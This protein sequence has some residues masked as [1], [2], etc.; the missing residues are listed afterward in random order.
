MVAEA[1]EIAEYKVQTRDHRM[2]YTR[3]FVIMTSQEIL[4]SGEILLSGFPITSQTHLMK[5]D[6]VFFYNPDGDLEKVVGHEI[7]THDEKD[8]I[9]YMFTMPD[10]LMYE[11]EEILIKRC[12]IS[13]SAHHIENKIHE[14]ENMIMNM[15]QETNKYIESIS[16]APIT[17]TA[18]Y[19]T[20][21]STPTPASTLV[22]KEPEKKE[23]RKGRKPNQKRISWTADLCLEFLEDCEKL[24]KK[25]VANKWSISPSA[26]TQ[27]RDYCTNKLDSITSGDH[28]QNV[29]N[30]WTE[31]NCKEFL[32]D[33]E[34]LSKDE[35]AQKW[36]V[37]KL[38]LPQKKL[39][40]TKKLGKIQ[41]TNNTKPTTK[42]E[43]AA[44]KSA[45]K[46]KMN[47][48][49]STRVEKDYATILD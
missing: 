27:K 29:K 39:Y 35:L 30:D 41:K 47:Q 40:C 36:N 8:F 23:E 34:V 1:E 10:D 32:S 37:M 43:K 38:Y 16:S 33:Y 21:N 31:E 12:G 15:K 19:I 6:D 9:R 48:A 49:K 3:P 44:A 14:L 13:K 4:D 22:K 5:E 25:E 26:V 2:A 46:A 24:S 42:A 17:R 7:V 28:P 11:L 20:E 45:K 18:I